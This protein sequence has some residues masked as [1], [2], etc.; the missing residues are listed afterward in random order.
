MHVISG[1]FYDLVKV[2]MAEVNE[3]DFESREYQDELFLQA[4]DQNLI[5]YLPTGSGK[6]FIAILLI[7]HFNGNNEM[8]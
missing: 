1:D 4:I 2:S 8:R 5:L 3:T 7:K 6:T